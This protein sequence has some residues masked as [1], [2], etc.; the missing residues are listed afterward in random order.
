[1]KT[2]IHFS[3]ALIALLGAGPAQA[4]FRMIE[5]AIE[6]SPAQ[7]ALPASVGD[8]LIVRDCPSCAPRPFRTTAATEYLVGSRS[9]PLADFARFLADNPNV[10]LTVMTS[11]RDGA[12]TRVKV[13]SQPAARGAGP[14]R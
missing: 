8:S 13:Q 9:L 5:Q 12:V 3:L 1:M 4:N 7:I 6:A 14:A 2:V 10:N 11:V